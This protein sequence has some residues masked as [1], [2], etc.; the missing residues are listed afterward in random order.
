MKTWQTWPHFHRNPCLQHLQLFN[1]YNHWLS[2]S[3]TPKLTKER[4]T[5]THTH[6]HFGQTHT[7][8]KYSVLRNRRSL[9]WR[10][11]KIRCWKQIWTDIGLEIGFRAGVES[12]W[13]IRLGNISS[14]ELERKRISHQMI[15]LPSKCVLLSLRTVYSQKL[16]E[17][18]SRRAKANVEAQSR[19]FVFNS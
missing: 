4:T 1:K 15:F 6:T 9:Q 2:R 17:M 16:R 19:S 3:R 10:R 14:T 13:F 7:T 18:Y 8:S 12:E 11:D 5:H